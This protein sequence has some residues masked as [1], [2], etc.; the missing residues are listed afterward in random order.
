VTDANGCVITRTIAVTQPTAITA[1]STTVTAI[2]GNPN[3]AATVTPSGG[4]PGYT[5]SWAPSGGTGATASG[6]AAGTYTCTITDANGCTFT[7]SVTIVN[8][9]SPA[10]SIV[11]STNILCFGGNNGSSTATATGGTGPYTYAWTPS[12]GT[13]ATA[14]GLIAGA[15]TVTATD[16]NGCTST[17]T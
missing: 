2:C 1:T 9:G 11:S 17:A 13:G 5:Y 15:Y 3:G 4:T 12:G 14:T 16:A 6:L 7:H 8:A 10:A